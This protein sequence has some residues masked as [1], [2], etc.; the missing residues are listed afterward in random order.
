MSD[1]F[2][3]LLNQKSR[4]SQYFY[5]W[6]DKVLVDYLAVISLID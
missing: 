4:K 5:T 3:R 6:L 2:V 1:I